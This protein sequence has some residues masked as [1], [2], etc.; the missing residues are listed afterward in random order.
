MI[1]IAILASSA[2]TAITP[3]LV[4]GGEE[5]ASEAGKN[6]FSWLKDKLSLSNKE[7]DLKALQA[8]PTDPKTQGRMEIILEEILSKNST[9]LPELSKLVENAQTETNVSISNSKNVITGNI[10]S[11]GYSI[12]G[13]NNQVS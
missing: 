13:D 10:T 5:I 9:L 11:G 4:K 6:L 7:K 2:V 1:D 8:N 3:Y 12:V